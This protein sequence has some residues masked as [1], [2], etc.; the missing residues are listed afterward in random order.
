MMS[1]KRRRIGAWRRRMIAKIPPQ[2][3]RGRK[4]EK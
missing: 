1:P 2:M 3:R 4:R